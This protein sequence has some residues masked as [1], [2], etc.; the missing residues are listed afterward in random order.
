ML[1]CGVDL[2][3]SEARLVLVRSETDGFFHIPCETRKLSLSDDCDA[4]ALKVLFRAIK[5]FAHQNGVE[6]FVIKARNKKGKMVGGAVSFKIETLFQLS[7]CPVDF[8]SAQALSCFTKGN[9]GGVPAT[10]LENQKDAFRSAAL[11]LSKV[12]AH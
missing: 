12:G 7:D 5:S 10:V 11:Y 1:I 3:A 9:M 2:K 8:V 6:R 4:A